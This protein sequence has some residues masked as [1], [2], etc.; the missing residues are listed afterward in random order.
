[1][2]CKNGFFRGTAI[3]MNPITLSVVIPVFNEAESLNLLHQKIV[4]MI[5]RNPQIKDWEL[6]FVDDGSSDQ[7]P[8]IIEQLAQTEPQ[9]SALFLRM[10]FGKAAALQA[11]FEHAK[12][13]FIVTMDSDLQDDPEEIPRL[14]NK[15]LEGYDLVSGWKKDR[16]DPT[17]KRWASK[18]FNTVVRF[19]SGLQLHDFNCGLKLYRSWCLKELNLRGNQH[20]YIPV[21]LFWKGAK[22]TELPV[23]HFSRQF[24][25]SKYGLARYF[26]GA[27]DLLTTML[28][29]RFAPNPLYFFAAFAVPLLGLGMALG[30]YLLLFHIFYLLELPFGLQLNN[31]PLLTIA[32]F[33]FLMGLQIGLI[34]LVAELIVRANPFKPYVVGRRIK[35]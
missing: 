30:L 20:R 3:S 34:G 26:Y 5:Q 33:L 18:F 10:N 11:G 24:G 1:M 6:I 29:T 31:R 8:Q 32:V 13:E 16:N 7:S 35:K 19:A 4:S 2:S 28:V 12:Y 17:E 9:T 27:F 21:L 22:V 25:T 14:I 23:R 15:A